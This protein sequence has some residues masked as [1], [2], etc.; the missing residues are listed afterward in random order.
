MLVKQAFIF[1]SSILLSLTLLILERSIGIDWDYH[2]DSVTYRTVSTEVF[3]SLYERGILAFINGGY[4]AVVHML[5][6]NIFLVTAMNIILYA[7]TNVII[8]KIHWDSRK[9]KIISIVLFLLLLNPYRVHLSTT[10]L[11][12]TL[13]IFLLVL[14]IFK[15]KY[16]FIFSIPLLFTRIV[17]LIYFITKFNR[18]FLIS[19]FLL[20]LILFYLYPNIFIDRLDASSSVNLNARDF[21]TIPTFQEYGNIGNFIRALVWPA[22]ALTGIFGL[23]SPSFAFIMVSLG[24][25]MNFAYL[26][27]TIKKFPISLNIFI[28]ISIIAILAPGFTSF[29]RYAY[30]ILTIAPLII[31]MKYNKEKT[32]II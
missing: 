28:P 19:G 11:K 23:L 29:I 27:L 24:I 16:F 21:D 13:V 2:P 15:F 3:Y 5:N 22:L 17:S 4:Y 7:F 14:C 26:Y 31:L 10:M 12:D 32:H 8:A 25:F 18:L 20:A 1:C 30:P 6:Q 9:F